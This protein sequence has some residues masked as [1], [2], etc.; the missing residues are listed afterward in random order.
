MKKKSVAII[1]AIFSLALIGML[2]SQWLW[3][4]KSYKLKEEQ[5]DHRIDMALNDVIGEFKRYFAPENW[6]EIV[7]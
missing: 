1:I 6:E 5:F 2:F 4:N 7:E 3:I